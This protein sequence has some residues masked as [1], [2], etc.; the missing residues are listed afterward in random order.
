[1]DVSYL[2][3]S[4]NEP[5]DNGMFKISWADVGR[6]LVVAV[7]APALVAVTVAL[8]AVISSAGFDVFSVDWIALSHNLLNISIVSA[9]GGFMGYLSKNFLSDYKGNVLSIGSK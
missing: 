7:F 2:F 8:G 6:G 5:M 9:Y 1:M 3:L 4:Y